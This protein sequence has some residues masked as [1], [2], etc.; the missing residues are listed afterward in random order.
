MAHAVFRSHQPSVELS[1]PEVF[2]QALRHRADKS[3]GWVMRFAST[4]YSLVVASLT[5]VGDA[6]RLT[7]HGMGDCWKAGKLTRIGMKDWSKAA[8]CMILAISA[9]VLG[10]LIP[11]AAFWVQ[12]SLGLVASIPTFLQR[13]STTIGLAASKVSS[14]VGKYIGPLAIPMIA[15]TIIFI[16]FRASYL[17]QEDME[18]LKEYWDKA[19]ELGRTVM[20]PFEIVI[21]PMRVYVIEPTIQAFNQ[22][23]P[24][25]QAALSVAAIVG[26]YLSLLVYS[27]K[28]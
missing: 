2:S 23:K 20:Q 14:F 8:K 27:I 9:I 24:V 6:I 21:D 19:K 22:L 26:T 1:S 12:T 4:R 16:V 28:D 15:F 10:L 11:R 5:A 7:V 17:D 18:S 13:C 3:R 25:T